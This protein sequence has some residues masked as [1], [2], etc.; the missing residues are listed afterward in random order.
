MSADILNG[1]PHRRFPRRLFRHS[2]GLLAH[3]EYNI[4]HGIEV[5]EG[6]MLVESNGPI[7]NADHIVVNFYIPKK[8]FV[9][10][11]GVV[12]YIKPAN[13]KRGPAYGVQFNNLTFENKRMIRD[14][15]ADKTSEEVSL[16]N[17]RLETA[18][19]L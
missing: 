6:G 16:K 19:E 9:S 7:K 11:T 8:G 4:V 12:V 13:E 3:A 2:V 5:G 1:T 14:Y 15:I 17:S 18:D 10:V